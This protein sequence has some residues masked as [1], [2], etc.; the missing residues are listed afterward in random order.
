VP[1]PEQKAHEIDAEEAG[2]PGD[3]AGRGTLRR[4]DV[5]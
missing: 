4:D 3:Q 1:P 5:V 2:T